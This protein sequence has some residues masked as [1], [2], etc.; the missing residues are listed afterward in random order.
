MARVLMVLGKSV[1]ALST[2][3][4]LKPLKGQGYRLYSVATGNTENFPFQSR[5]PDRKILMQ[6]GLTEGLLAIAADFDSK[7]ILLFTADED[8]VE[9]SRNRSRLEPF[10]D[11][12]LPDAEMVDLLMEKGKFDAFAA[13][14]QLSVP[15]TVHVHSEEELK[16]LPGRLRFPIILKPYLLHAIRIDEA[17]QLDALPKELDTVH[18]RSMIAQEFIEGGDDNLYFCFLLFNQQGDIVH[19]LTA[20]KLRQWPVSY[21]TTSL[22]KTVENNALW[23]EVKKFAQAIRGLG[24]C[25]VEYKFDPKSKRFYI[26]EPTVGRF[27]QQVSLSVA[28][29]VNFP[30]AYVRMLDGGAV[31]EKPQRSGIYWIFE[32]ND[33]FACLRSGKRYGYLKNFLRPHIRV[34]FSWT[35][36][37]PFLFEIFSLG[38]KKLRK[39]KFHV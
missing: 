30:L 36:P 35:D 18:Y 6:D 10:Y 34:L 12:M 29:G 31:Q 2:L 27:N 33:F 39:W 17:A 13:R 21:G 20:R 1:T 15:N 28:A 26:M 4:A 11:F 19:S 23:K 8:V 25:S 22:A 24:Y 32:S 16:K 38:R 7:P 5:I 9:T 37:M 14:H 3:R